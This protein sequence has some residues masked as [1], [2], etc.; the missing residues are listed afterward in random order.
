MNCY[1]VVMTSTSGTDHKN[2]QLDNSPTALS[3]SPRFPAQYGLCLWFGGNACCNRLLRQLLI[4][5]INT[6]AESPGKTALNQNFFFT[7]H[8]VKAHFPCFY[9]QNCFSYIE[10]YLSCFHPSPKL[11]YGRYLSGRI[12][13]QHGQGWL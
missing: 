11:Q 13:F 4:S 5:P 1:N 8:Q 6:G 12:A 2:T 7:L 10:Y 9:L 3:H